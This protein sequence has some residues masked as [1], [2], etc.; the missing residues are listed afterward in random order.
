MRSDIK[1]LIDKKAYRLKISY[2]LFRK[3]LKSFY[4]C[5]YDCNCSIK[6]RWC[7]GYHICFTRRRSRVRSSLEV[8]FFRYNNQILDLTLLTFSWIKKQFFTKELVIKHESMI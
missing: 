1:Y 3:T 6:L 2:S 7:S 5:N 8:S 4:D